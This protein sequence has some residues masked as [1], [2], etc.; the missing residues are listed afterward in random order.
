MCSFELAREYL[1]LFRFL[2]VFVYRVDRRLSEVVAKSAEPR[3]NCVTYILQS[4]YR[5]RLGLSSG[6]AASW[7][8]K[9][10]ILQW[11]CRKHD[12]MVSEHETDSLGY[13]TSRLTSWQILISSFLS[14]GCRR[15]KIPSLRCLPSR[16]VCCPVS[17]ARGV[18]AAGAESERD[19][20]TDV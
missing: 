6:L 10:K 7:P 4:R 20:T 3:H 8:C 1:G 13:N 16:G 14:V 9:K 19:E 18:R 12:L 17:S 11:S 15:Q 2:R 5:G